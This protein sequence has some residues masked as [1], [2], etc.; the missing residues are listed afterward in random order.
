MSAP[1]SAAMPAAT[2]AAISISAAISEH[3]GEEE[4]ALVK[5]KRWGGGDPEARVVG[6]HVLRE[7]RA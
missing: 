6:E 2:A 4:G 7:P 5:Q 3:G 1:T